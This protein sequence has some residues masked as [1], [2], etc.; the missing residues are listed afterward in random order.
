MSDLKVNRIQLGQNATA[1]QN[2]TFKQGADGTMTL[3]RGNA[4]ATTQDILTIDASGNVQ[5]PQGAITQGTAI[6]TT[7]GT[8]HDFTGIPS[9][10]KK[11]TVMFSGV[12]TNG[13][14]LPLLQIG[15]SGGIETTSYISTA[16]LL[17]TS[18]NSSSSQTTGFFLAN[19]GNAANTINGAITLNNLDGNIWTASGALTTAVGSASLVNGAK[20]LSGA[21]DRIRLTT[22]G[23][24]DT[25]D[26]GT[27]NILYEG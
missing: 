15:D 1:T 18:S 25:F 11:I 16:T 6:A 12:S 14:A 8:S 9:W 4:G 2:F 21:L 19:L 10:V 5:F 13:T 26:A 7:S 20:T 3:A 23:G 27:I 22:V 24:T 17:T